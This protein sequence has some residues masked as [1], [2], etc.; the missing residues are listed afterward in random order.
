MPQTIQSPAHAANGDGQ[1]RTAVVN[2]LNM[3]LTAGGAPS[4]R[5]MRPGQ[6]AQNAEAWAL[7]CRRQ[8]DAAETAGYGGQADLWLQAA[9]KAEELCDVLKRIAMQ[10]L[11]P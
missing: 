10:G 8:A 11:M 5:P 9:E 3:E 4:A 6:A 1:S 2:I 7:W